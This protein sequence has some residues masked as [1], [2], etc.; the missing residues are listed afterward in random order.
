[1]KSTGQEKI[2]LSHKQRTD[3]EKITLSHKQYS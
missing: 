1:L 3:Q 2:T